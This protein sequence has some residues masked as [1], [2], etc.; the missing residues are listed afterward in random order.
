MDHGKVVANED[1]DNWLYG[2]TNEGNW[3]KLTNWPNVK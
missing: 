1:D 2:G 3:Y